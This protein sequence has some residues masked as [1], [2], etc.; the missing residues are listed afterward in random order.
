VNDPLRR[1]GLPALAVCAA[2]TAFGAGGSSSE[3]T[4]PAPKPSPEQRAAEHYNAGLASRDEAWALEKKGAA[5]GLADA[6]RD[7]LAGKARKAYEAATRSFEK[8]IEA[9]PRMHQAWSDLGYARR[10]TGNY[11]GALTAY[12]QALALAP[13]YGRALEYLGEAYLGLDRVADAQGAYERLAKVDEKLAS[14]LLS[15][16]VSWI[17]A[18]RVEPG[19]I[20]VGELDALERWVGDRLTGEPLPSSLGKSR[21]W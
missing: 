12:E 7:K 5:D 8:A 3:T 20:K 19:P 17:G 13:D 16:M 11:A 4:P 9:D 10:Q 2:A 1:L 18:R 15:A 21:S 6:E 14:E